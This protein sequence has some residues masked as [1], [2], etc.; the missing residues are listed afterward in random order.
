MIDVKSTTTTSCGRQKQERY[1]V[2][3]YSHLQQLTWQWLLCSCSRFSAIVPL[4]IR[5]SSTGIPQ[6]FAQVTNA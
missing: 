3:K 6:A 1:I 4:D 2:D 5:L